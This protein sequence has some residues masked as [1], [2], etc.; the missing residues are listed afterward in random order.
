MTPWEKIIFIRDKINLTH[1]QKLIL[2]IIASHIGN[3]DFA[4]LSITTIQNECGIK[5]RTSVTDH[6][7]ALQEIG[8]ITILPPSDGY[9]TNRYLINLT[10]QDDEER[11]STVT[12]NQQSLVT[13]GY[14]QSSETS[15]RR[16]PQESHE[17]LSHEGKLVTDGY[18]GSNR[19][20]PDW[21]P[22]VTRV[23]TDGYPKRNINKNKINKKTTTTKKLVTS[24]K[25]IYSADQRLAAALAK[26]IFEN[27]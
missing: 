1:I 5:K 13:D 18:Q 7:Q 11:S 22:T 26:T 2:L 21:S 14:Q 8:L 6:L 4:Y 25:K 17:H 12:S 15:N 19:R 20:L 9:S 3:N 27:E 16:L 10:K 24:Q 23:V